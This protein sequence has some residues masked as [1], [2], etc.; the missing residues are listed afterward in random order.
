M[1]F[2]YPAR[3]SS[4]PGGRFAVTFPDLPDAIT[5]GNNREDALEMAADCLSATIQWRMEER[6]DIPVPSKIKRGQV[7][8]SVP[9]QVAAKAALYI[10]MKRKGV[11]F[12]ELARR[13][14][15]SQPIQA[16]R[17]VDPKMATSMKKID[18][19]LATMG[20]RLRVGIDDAA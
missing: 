7:G 9:L 1:D 19:A 16:R 17:L 14:N 12:S 4:Q 10:T 18:E 20:G 2:I 5:E 11:S 8:I 3:L 15:Y 6:G 13:L